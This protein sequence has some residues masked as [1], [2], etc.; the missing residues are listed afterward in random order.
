MTSGMIFSKFRKT[1][2]LRGQ[3]ISLEQLLDAR[4]SRAN[5]QQ[6]CLEQYGETLL[7]LTLLAVGGVKKNALLDEIFAKALENLTALFQTLGVEITA[8]FIRPLETG[9]EALFV[10]PIDATLLKQAAMQLEDSS[11]LARLWDIDVIDRN[12]KLLSRADFDFPP[13]PCLVCN[14]NA[15]SCA[16][17][18]K[19]SFD[20]IFAEMQR[21]VQAVDFSEQIAEFAY[22]AL[23]SEARLSPKP[24][25][26]DSINNGSH[27]DMNLHTFEQSA[28]A[29]KPFF[30]HF[31]LEGMKTA[32]GPSSQILRQIRPLG[33]QAE[34]AMLQATEQVNTHKGAIF[35]FGLVC[36][37]IGRLYQQHRLAMNVK[38][39]CEMVA[40]FTQ[41]LCAEL[42]YFPKNQ[43]LT[44]GVQ[45][46]QQY[47]LTGARGEAESGFALIRQTIEFLSS[48]QASSTEH[49]WLMALVYLMAVNPDTN[50]IHRGGMEGL[51]F[52]QQEAK[53]LLDSPSVLLNESE[54][55]NN[56][57]QLDQACIARNLS[58]GGSA[59]LLALLIFLKHYL[60]L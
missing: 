14:D 10:L 35:A 45:L 25:L 20:E 22:Q 48:K 33:L 36:T 21:R 4:E 47:G 9:H 6:Q 37:A 28:L 52:V 41:G 16:R 39:I 8:Q 40:E 59:D 51:K 19:H 18:R 12:G 30:S 44:A 58:S 38:Q 29:L 26:V 50:V 24:G 53:K 5:L 7:S 11:P 43:L 42:Q 55:K 15:K 23:V 49:Q 60:K 3:T 17:S 27:K 31:V 46:F 57:S 34:Q 1:F 13:R 54:L 2:S 32:E 56:L